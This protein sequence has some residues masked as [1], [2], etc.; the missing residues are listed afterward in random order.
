MVDIELDSS[1]IEVVR[2]KSDTEWYMFSTLSKLAIQPYNYDK[3][4]KNLPF[5][6]E[7]WCNSSFFLFF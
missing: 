3:I 4:N 2:M 7:C 6:N 5:S 1:R